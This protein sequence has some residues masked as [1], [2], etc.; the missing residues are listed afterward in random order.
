MKRYTR[1]KAVKVE[2]N[3]ESK[4]KRDF[5]EKVSEKKYQLVLEYNERQKY[6]D[7]SK[8]NDSAK[9]PFIKVSLSFNDSLITS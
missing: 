2:E 3:A 9:D 7:L 1:K 6:K 5:Q 8:E 4:K